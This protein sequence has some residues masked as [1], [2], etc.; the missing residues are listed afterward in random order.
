MYLLSYFSIFFFFVTQIIS[1]MVKAKIY[2]Q[3]P[4]SMDSEWILF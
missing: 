1:N 2:F 4:A 3:Q